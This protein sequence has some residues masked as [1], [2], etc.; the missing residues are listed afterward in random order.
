MSFSVE[1]QEFDGHTCTQSTSDCYDSITYLSFYIEA[2]EFLCQPLAK[3]V[4]SERIQLLIGKD[5]ASA[6][7]MLSTVEDAFLAL[8]Q[9]ILYSPRYMY[10]Q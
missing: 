10:I 1:D 5:D 6:M 7:T 9:F 4:N 3:S 8:C 2:L